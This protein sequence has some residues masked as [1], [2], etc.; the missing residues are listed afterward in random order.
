VLPVANYSLE[1]RISGATPAVE[2][3]TEE[4]LISFAKMEFQ[5]EITSRSGSEWAGHILHSLT[6]QMILTAGR[7]GGIA[8][9][10]A[11]GTAALPQD[12]GAVGEHDDLPLLVKF[13]GLVV[14]TSLVDHHGR[15][16]QVVGHN[17]H[18]AGI[19]AVHKELHTIDE[20]G[21]DV[22][23]CD[24]LIE[25]VN[26]IEFGRLLAKDQRHLPHATEGVQ[27]G[28][29][30]GSAGK[31][32]VGDASRHQDGTGAGRSIGY[33]GQNIFHWSQPIL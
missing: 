11:S 4:V 9:A 7:M 19:H 29:S 31:E 6:L 20:L 5:V 27:G 12:G 21:Q 17:L 8:T 24:G 14:I 3:Q 10:L 26:R 16:V 18:Q 23:T 1:L 28:T 22:D 2:E 33:I 30:R 25:E 13:Q 32:Q 15:V